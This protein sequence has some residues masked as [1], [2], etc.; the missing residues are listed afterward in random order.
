MAKKKKKS[1]T[2]A[3]TDVV[4]SCLEDV[5]LDVPF[6]EDNINRIKAI[7][8]LNEDIIKMEELKVRQNETI[9]KMASD[10]AELKAQKRRDVIGWGID[11]LKVVATIG[12]TLF[13]VD[14][15]NKTSWYNSTSG[16]KEFVK[17]IPDLTGVFKKK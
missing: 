17:H 12:G 11:I 15:E 7:H 9:V 5:E 13:L 10:A 16:G 2:E 14:V 4:L 3:N 1:L 8:S 6:T